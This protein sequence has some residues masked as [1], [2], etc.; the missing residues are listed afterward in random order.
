MNKFKIISLV[1]ISAFTVFLGRAYELYF[2][3]APFRAIL[4]DESLLTPIVEGLSNYSWADYAT[5][6]R[7]NQW[8]DGFTKASSFIFLAA[9][10]VSLFWDKIKVL[11]VKKIILSVAMF[12]LLVIGICMVKDKNYEYLLFFELFI[13]FSAPVLLLLNV[14]FDVI[15]NKKI[16]NG[17][18]I[19][20]A[21]TFIA[22]GLFA[23][24]LIYLP[25]HFVDMTIIILDVNEAQAT[26]FLYIVGLLDIVASIMIFIPKLSK[27]ALLYMIYWG[28]STA[29]ARL[30]SGYSQ[31]FMASSIHG[32]LYLVIYRLSHGIVP[33][34]VLIIE[35]KL[36]KL[37]LPTNEI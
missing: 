29:F 9:A 12:I 34:L 7:V 28:F 15:E 2:F 1:K 24:G 16:I 37:K 3:G 25:G 30:M 22:H 10:L 5:S 4:W 11:R 8:I 33:L 26:S 31:N 21:S 20:I 13:Q 18:K 36:K 27:Y 23:M 14:R 32:S 35:E 17:L 6:S 19:A